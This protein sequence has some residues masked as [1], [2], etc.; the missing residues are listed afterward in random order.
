MGEAMAVML[1]A[2]MGLVLF[3]HVFSLPANWIALALVA[4]WITMHPGGSVTWAFFGVL[5][6]LAVGG[7]VL[8]FIIQYYGAKAFGS[9]GKGNV[10]GM[11]G[12]VVGAILGAPLLLGIGAVFGALVGA[13]AGCLIL[14]LGQGRG[15]GQAWVAAWGA[16][17]GKFFGMAVKFGVGVA[18]IALVVSRL[19][20]T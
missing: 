12:A 18:M 6:G 4:G 9:T 2:F 7:E 20:A 13:F 8:E 15:A 1:V 5:A 3:L 11:V 19:W 10:G 17:F 14:E 16:M